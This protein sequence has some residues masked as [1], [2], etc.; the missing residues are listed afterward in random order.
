[1]H[2]RPFSGSFVW[3]LF[4]PAEGFPFPSEP[5]PERAPV[6]VSPVAVGPH[7]IMLD[8]CGKRIQMHQRKER[9]LKHILGFAVAQPQRPSI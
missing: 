7:T 1:M 6:I 5:P 9:L 4:E 2:G 3:R 8:F